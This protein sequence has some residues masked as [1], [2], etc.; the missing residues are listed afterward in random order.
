MKLI[1]ETTCK[2]CNRTFSSLRKSCPHCGTERDTIK[3]SSLPVSNSTEKRTREAN[4]SSEDMNWQLILGGLV[5]VALLATTVSVTASQINRNIAEE[6][7]EIEIPVVEV[8]ATAKPTET[9]APTIA[10]TEAPL[11][12]SLSI[13]F[14]GSDMEGYTCSVGDVIDLDEIHYPITADVTV[15][16]YSSDENVAVVDQDG[17]V[18]AVSGGDY[19]Y[20]Y[21]EVEGY[22]PDRCQVVVR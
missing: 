18:T 5:L 20:I 7:P 10:P 6:E 8:A 15:K 4:A 12:T 21:C 14:N 3:R 2:R 9:P 22:E 13:V 1:P 11:I 19:C 16:W 17:V